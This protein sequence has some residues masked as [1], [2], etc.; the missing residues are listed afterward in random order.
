MVK[1]KPPATFVVFEEDPLVH[2]DI[3]D[4]LSHGFRD[5]PLV[6]VEAIEQLPSA[7]AAIEGHRIIVSSADADEILSLFAKA[8]VCPRNLA[9]VLIAK[10]TE[11][12]RTEL[13]WLSTVPHPFKSAQLLDAVKTSLA[14]LLGRP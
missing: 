10:G 7:L 5:W 6:I 11:A 14:T 2:M 9:A 1:C 4:L 3:V 13:N 8:A 12:I